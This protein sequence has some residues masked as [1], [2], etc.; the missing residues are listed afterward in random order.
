M[1]TLFLFLLL[2]LFSCSSSRDIVSQKSE[3]TI[4][5]DSTSIEMA[6]SMSYDMEIVRGAPLYGISFSLTADSVRI[7]DTVFYNPVFNAGAD[8]LKPFETFSANGETTEGLK[9]V[10]VTDSVHDLHSESETASRTE[11]PGRLFNRFFLLTVLTGI[12]GSF[13]YC[14]FKYKSR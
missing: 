4:V 12:A 2:C 13:L 8:S 3:T 6:E 14:F 1:R 10:N 9:A 7:G 5:S 11:A